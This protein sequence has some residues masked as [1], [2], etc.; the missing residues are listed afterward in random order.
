[1]PKPVGTCTL[2]FPAV[3]NAPPWLPVTSCIGES[4]NALHRNGDLRPSRVSAWGRLSR[5]GQLG[6]V[7][8]AGAHRLMDLASASQSE[9]RRLNRR[10]RAHFPRR[11]AQRVST[12]AHAHAS[13]VA[14]HCVPP[15]TMKVPE[16]V[17]GELD[18]LG[19]LRIPSSA[20]TY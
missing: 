5:S 19:S 17:V 16:V 13:T 1:M 9:V 7:V 20:V 18:T 6:V 4:P 15:R 8:V 12:Y 14:Y 10:Q 2:S 3:P 11:T